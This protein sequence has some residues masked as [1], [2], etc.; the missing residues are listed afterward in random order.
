M[1]TR[2]VAIRHAKPSGDGYSEDSI[3][4]LSE[5]GVVIQLRVAQLLKEEGIS[6]SKILTSPLIRAQQT[7][8]IISTVFNVPFESE[9]ALGND[10]NEKTLLKRIP[11]P[12]KNQTIFLVGHTP[13]LGDLVNKLVGKIVLPH[14]LSKSSAAVLDFK[15]SVGLGFATFVK[16]YEP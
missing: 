6:P 4:P 9:R 14:G 8:K 15:E 2:L 3:R 16:Y 10:F 5:E 11:A 1:V 12:E 7:A 13:T